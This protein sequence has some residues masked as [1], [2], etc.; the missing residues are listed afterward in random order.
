MDLSIFIISWTGQHENAAAIARSLDAMRGNVTIIYSDPDP[1]VEPRAECQKIRRPNELFW[2]DKFQACLKATAGDQMLVLHADCQCD[3][4]PALVEKFLQT[5]ATLPN[6]GV[7][8]PLMRGCEL[9]VENTRIA[10]IDGTSLSLV[11]HTD[12]IC[13][14]ITG[15]ILRRMRRAR[16]EGNLYGW[17][18]AWL[19]AASAL[20]RNM[21]VV[22][23]ES[24]EVRHTPGRGYSTDDA[25]RQ[26]KNFRKQFSAPETV[27]HVMMDN[28]I[29]R[30]KNKTAPDAV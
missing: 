14:A 29:M 30:R 23:D 18:I 13:F 4:W 5:V 27:Q 2:T 9:E 10:H 21:L 6:M 24:I 12:A 22:V 20:C 3:D 17:G 1:T 15:K 19:M 25:K 11:I 16:Y 28:F 7:W 8:A 26:M